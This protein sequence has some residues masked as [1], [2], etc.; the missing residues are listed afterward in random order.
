MSEKNKEGQ[1]YTLKV[2]S[3]HLFD[4]HSSVTFDL[5]FYGERIFAFQKEVDNPPGQLPEYESIVNEATLD[6]QN[7]LT[8]MVNDLCM[9]IE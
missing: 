7:D 3:I 2:S 5:L 4:D 8:L 1:A 6:M 9:Y